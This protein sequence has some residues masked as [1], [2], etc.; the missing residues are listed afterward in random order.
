MD[1]RF[2]DEQTMTAEA[3]RALLADRCQ[4]QD[5]RRLMQAGESRDDSRW[6]AIVEMGLLGALAPE[7]VGGLGLSEPDFVQIAEACGY[8]ALPEPL[9]EAAGVATPLLASLAERPE[10]AALLEKVLA[11]EA[12]VVAAHPINPVIADADLAAG[13]LSARGGELHLFTAESLSFV[14]QPSVDPF[15]R[16]FT[17]EETTGES[18]KLAEG[19]VAARALLDALDRGALFA[20]AQLLGVAQRAVAM[21]ADYARERKQFGKPIGSYQAI[22][23]LLAAAQVKIEFTRPVVYAAAAECAN[24]DA[25]SRARI[26]HAK[27]AAADAADAACRA[28]VQAHGA[29]GY[30]WEVDVH[31]FLKRALALSGWWGDAAFHRARAATRVFG[32]PLGP[33]TTFAADAK[34]G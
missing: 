31:L 30:S 34:N 22:K 9:V 13:V 19:A 1:F 21:A 15:R 7:S 11:G 18:V 27:L 28:A 16:L 32:R 3:V 5:L 23:H 33:E 2:T 14:R 25:F 26:S 20:A 8:A 24:G 10:A 4:P 6:A 17:M 12:V 29:M